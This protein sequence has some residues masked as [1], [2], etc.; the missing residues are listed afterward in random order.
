MVQVQPIRAASPVSKNAPAAASGTAHGQIPA[1]RAC[2]QAS[3]STCSAAMTSSA[4]AAAP[5]QICC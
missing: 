2:D 3:G 4:P 1:A 5:S